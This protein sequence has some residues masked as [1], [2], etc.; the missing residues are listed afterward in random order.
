MNAIKVSII[1]PIYNVELYLHKCL[2]SLVNQTLKDIEIICI[3]DCSLDN[4]LAM[5]KEYAEKDLRIKI[6]DFEKNQGVSVARNA[7]IEAAKGEYIGFC[8]PD[9][10]VDLDFYG[11][12]HDKAKETGTGMVKASMK[13]KRKEWIK[14]YASYAE[15]KKSKYRGIFNPWCYIYKTDIV[16]KYQISYPEGIKL[17]ED[18]FF[19][20]KALY[21]FN[22]IEVVSDVFYHYIAREGAA[23][24]CVDDVIVNS[25]GMPLL[26]DFMNREIKDENEYKDCFSNTFVHTFLT[27]FGRVIPEYRRVFASI[28]VDIYKN[29]KCSVTLEDLPK[30]L[31][32]SDLENADILFE[33]LNYGLDFFKYPE[34]KIDNLQNRKLY[35]WGAG[36]DGLSVL[37]QCDSNGWKVEAFLDSN[38]QAKKYQEHKV[39]QPQ[40][41][42]DSKDRDFFIIISSRDYADEIA[43]VCERAGLREGLDFWK[44]E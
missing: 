11:K 28:A 8:D 24:S 19:L 21:Y 1:V 7:G 33:K 42:L 4:S 36:Y 43:Q 32:Q 44:P 39:L 31:E 20:V 30:L 23:T 37:T 5:L 16:K 10:Y 34:I 12:L 2:D 9:D 18:S 6:I 35:V 29:R 13:S 17:S 15:I 22:K 26:F 41:L 14:E 40:Y 38:P 27:F 25:Y 3:N